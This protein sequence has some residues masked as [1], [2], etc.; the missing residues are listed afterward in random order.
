MAKQHNTGNPFDNLTYAPYVSTFVGM[1][2]D[3]IKALNIE[4]EKNYQQ[5]LN[6]SDVLENTIKGIK[7]TSEIDKPKLKAAQD[8]LRGFIDDAV[9]EGNLKSKGSLLRKYAKTMDETFGLSALQNKEAQ[10]S[11]VL[12]EMEKRV[13]EGKLNRQDFETAR[14][15]ADVLYETSGGLQR[16]PTT[17][18]WEANWNMYNLS[19]SINPVDLLIDSSSG[20]FKANVNPVMK[21]FD[22]V[23]GQ[24]YDAMMDYVPGKGFIYADTQEAVEPERVRAFAMQY[25]GNDPQFKSH[26]A[27]Q[28]YLRNVN[29][30]LTREGYREPTIDDLKQIINRSNISNEELD[31]LGLTDTTDETLQKAIEKNGGID[32]L[33]K[34]LDAV[35]LSNNAI[36]PFVN[37]ESYSKTDRRFYVDWEEKA[38]LEFEA[39][40]A[41]GAKPESNTTGDG[42]IDMLVPITTQQKISPDDMTAK[43]TEWNNIQA[44]YTELQSQILKAEKDPTID[45]T[46][47][48]EKRKELEALAK[49]RGQLKEQIEFVRNSVKSKVGQDVLDDIWNRFDIA[50][51]F[52]I[53][54]AEKLLKDFEFSYGRIAEAEKQKAEDFLNHKVLT[55]EE[56]LKKVIDEYT[57]GNT[58]TS[59]IEAIYSTITDFGSPPPYDE[60]VQ[61]HINS[62]AGTIYNKIGKFGSE[63]IGQQFYAQFDSATMKHSGMKQ[64][65]N[66]ATQALKADKNVFMDASSGKDLQTLAEDILGLKTE[67]IN[68]DK[69]TITPL[70]GVDENGNPLFAVSLYKHA[71]KKNPSKGDHSVGAI[72]VSMTQDSNARSVLADYVSEQMRG[73]LNRGQYGDFNDSYGSNTDL[74]KFKVLSKFYADL[75]GIGKE[76]DNID[77]YN[78]NP[79]DVKVWEI[80]FNGTTVGLNIRAKREVGGTNVGD[81]NYYL[82]LNGRTFGIND[83]GQWGWWDSSSISEPKSFDTAAEIKSEIGGAIFKDIVDKEKANNIIQGGYGYNPYPTRSQRQGQSIHVNLNLSSDM[84]SEINFNNFNFTSTNILPNN[85]QD[86]ANN[87]GDDIKRGFN[88][89]ITS[90]GLTNDEIQ[91]NATYAPNSGHSDTSKHYSGNAIDIQAKSSIKKK[92]G[93]DQY[94]DITTNTWIYN[95]GKYRV[96]YEPGRNGS[97]TNDSGHFHIE[98]IS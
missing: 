31:S 39:N 47:L 45:K 20:K 83:S 9:L 61:N 79:D 8:D 7:P 33:I 81:L 53:K 52:E 17:G 82:E 71:D 98:V 62:G 69:S 57:Q 97:N 19:D 1:P 73:I 4:Q 25:L 23:S 66:V 94:A 24:Y 40:R 85:K 15:A 68:W 63:P 75:T 26:I 88:S 41:T 76:L 78:M 3:D 21:R 35:D 95:D 54:A 22:P 77:I 74:D 55:K 10:K 29:R 70:M 32:N 6:D 92:L 96:L 42:Y 87:L 16:N 67:Q 58:G 18:E 28:T 27:D 56:F 86:Y 34:N 38:R 13:Q 36:Q 72:T 14:A 2:I 60:R 46:Q 64:I 11:A 80:P 50:Q 49:R 91:I 37:L 12:A 44:Q 93:L 5:F 51:Q 90:L 30:F 84:S 89:F 59:I 65:I 43:I 48:G